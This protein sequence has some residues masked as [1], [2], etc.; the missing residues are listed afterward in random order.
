ML[1]IS[2]DDIRRWIVEIEEAQDFR[3][4]EFGEY[5]RRGNVTSGAG[6]NLDCF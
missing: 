1:P 3:K 6:V 4:R 2:S 5:R